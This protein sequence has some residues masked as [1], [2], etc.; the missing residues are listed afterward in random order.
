MF[1]LTN[2]P[3]PSLPCF[4]IDLDNFRTQS[5]Y[6]KTHVLTKFYE[7]WTKNVPSR[8]FTLPR[9]LAA[10]FFAPILTIFEL[11]RDINEINILTKFH[12]DWANIVTSRVFTRNTAPPP[13]RP[14]YLTDRNHF[15][16][17]HTYRLEK[18]FDKIT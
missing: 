10:M 9:P 3:T 2:C 4:S 14:Y 8:V 1:G 16:T 6:P 15:L 13:L 7:D 17:Q 11:V 5:S 18:H 12:D